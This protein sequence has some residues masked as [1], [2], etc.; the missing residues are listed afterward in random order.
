M[1]AIRIFSV[2]KYG[3]SSARACDSSRQHKF[4]FEQHELIHKIFNF[5]FRKTSFPTS[6]AVSCSVASRQDRWHRAA[7]NSNARPQR[8][9]VVC[10]QSRSH[11]GLH[12]PVRSCRWGW[13]CWHFR[14]QQIIIFDNNSSPNHLLDWTIPRSSRHSR[15]RLQRTSH[16][17]LSVR[18]G[19]TESPF[20][21]RTRTASLSKRWGALH[22]M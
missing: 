5:H 20:P 11:H 18:E 19:T 8:R 13:F 16:N 7:A 10:E 12:R 4:N 15:S 3:E 22:R 2:G 21:W 17:Q 14:Q 9:L 6:N 1:S